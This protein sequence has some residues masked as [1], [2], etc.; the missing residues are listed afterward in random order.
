M[1]GKFLKV[2]SLEFKV[3]SSKSKI[4]SG[5]S[6]LELMISMFVIIILLSVGLPAY[7]RTVQHARETVLAE[8]LRQMRNAIQQYTVDKGKL[9]KS[10]SDLVTEHYFS[11][12]P[13]DPVLG[14]AE[15][16]EIQG[17]DTTSPDAEQGLKDVKTLNEGEDSDGKKF[18][19]Y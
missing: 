7:Q 14:K 6:L 10:V 18:E 3:Q 2:Q 16:K 15:W 17:E 5:F 12:I 19:D 4:E 13:I 8:N 1:I 9:P 11:E